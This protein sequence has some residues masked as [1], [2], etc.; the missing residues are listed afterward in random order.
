MEYALLLIIFLKFSSHL[1]TFPKGKRKKGKGKTTTL[2]ELLQPQIHLNLSFNASV[3]MCLH[4]ATSTSSYSASHRHT[5]TATPIPLR[6]L[7]NHHPHDRWNMPHP[8]RF[9]FPGRLGNKS[10]QAS[11]HRSRNRQGAAEL[12]SQRSGFELVWQRVSFG[13]QNGSRA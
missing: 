7:S 5:E 2:R 13:L 4:S 3:A 6:S 1:P 11:S 10:G 9:L 12:P 8:V